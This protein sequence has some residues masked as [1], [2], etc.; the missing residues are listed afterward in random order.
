MTSLMHELFHEKTGR[1]IT[2]QTFS[3]DERGATVPDVETAQVIRKM[4]GGKLRD[5]PSALG[6]R[7][8]GPQGSPESILVDLAVLR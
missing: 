4:T 3:N 5:T 2:H 1:L 8:P 7:E 6:S